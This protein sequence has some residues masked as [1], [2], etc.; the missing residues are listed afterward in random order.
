MLKKFKLIHPYH[1]VN[2]SPWPLMV[3]ISLL[4]LLISIVLVFNNK[5]GYFTLFILSIS[6]LNISVYLWIE[7]IINEGVYKG[8]HTKRV[9]Y[10]LFYGFILF[11]ISEVS[12]FTSLFFSFFYNSLIPSVEL[13]CDWPPLGINILN[14][15]SIPLYNTLLLYISGITITITQ[16]YINKRNKDESI[17]YLFFTIFLG[18]VFSYN[19]YLEYKFASFTISDSIYSTCF[20]ILTGFHGVH[21]IIGTILLIVSFL[22]LLFHQFLYKNPVGL[23]TSAI[24]WHFVDYVWLV[25]FAALYCWGS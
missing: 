14:P 3:S 20:Y 5:E 10:N 24:Y 8:E 17:W 23:N 21:V 22:R 16:N 18:S 25:L 19:Q 7:E 11:V 6:L 2:F 13:G 9:Q 15:E 12:I 4:Y 1:I